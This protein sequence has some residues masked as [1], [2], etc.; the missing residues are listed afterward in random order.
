MGCDH[1]LLYAQTVLEE[2]KYRKLTVYLGNFNTLWDRSTKQN[3]SAASFVTT[4]A[5]LHP[6]HPLHPLL[7]LREVK[8]IIFG[9]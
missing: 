9:C 5:P 2:Q 1:L 8:F 7:E 6:L 4:D 3:M